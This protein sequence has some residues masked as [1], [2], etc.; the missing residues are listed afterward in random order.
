MWVNKFIWVISGTCFFSFCHSATNIPVSTQ[1]KKTYFSDFADVRQAR[2]IKWPSSTW[3][4]SSIIKLGSHFIK[5]ERKT[6]KN[7][8]KKRKSEWNNNVKSPHLFDWTLLKKKKKS[9]FI[10]DSIRLYRVRVHTTNP[11]TLTKTI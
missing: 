9:I 6:K 4:V 2:K 8:K 10:W 11:K 5:I 7:N 3:S 1:L